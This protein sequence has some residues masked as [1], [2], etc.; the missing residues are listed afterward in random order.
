MRLFS[1]FFVYQAFAQNDYTNEEILEVVFE[2]AQKEICPDMKAIFPIKGCLRLV[3]DEARTA[4]RD[5]LRRSQ[6]VA[7]LE[8]KGLLPPGNRV[9]CGIGTSKCFNWP[10]YE[11]GCWCRFGSHLTKG[12]GQPQDDLDQ[13]CKDFQLCLR[14]VHI[15]A[16]IDNYECSVHDEITQ[17]LVDPKK[18][19]TNMNIYQTCQDSTTDECSKNT[20]CCASKFLSR[21]AKT[22]ISFLAPGDGAPGWS[23]ENKHENGFDLEKCENPDRNPKPRADECCGV[24]PTRRPYNTLRKNCC[25]N[26]NMYNP[27]VHQCCEDGSVGLSCE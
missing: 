6:L 27:N 24:Y 22:I 15:D 9:L 14:C 3:T 20:C 10:V 16:E 23:N 11:Y 18:M 5:P 17:V 21:W 26:K 13:V 8:E 2:N 1:L 19:K 7:N 4:I 25:K 12:R